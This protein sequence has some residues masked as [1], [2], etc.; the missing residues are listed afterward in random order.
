MTASAA[1]EN[2]SLRS[3]ALISIIASVE[4]SKNL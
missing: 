1:V 2:A 4:C 3:F